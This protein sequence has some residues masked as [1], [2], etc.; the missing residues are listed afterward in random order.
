MKQ[1]FVVGIGPGGGSS[2]T[3]AAARALSAADEIIGY[4]KY[5]ELVAEFTKGKGCFANGMTG[6]RERCARALE[7][8]SRGKTVCLVCSG[9]AGVYGMASLV[10]ELA[11]GF[12]P[13][14]VEIVPGVTAALAG[15]ALLG[16]PLSCDFCVVSLSDLLT[17]REKIAQRL[18]AAGEGDF[19]LALY[20]PRS[21]GR[22]GSLRDACDILLAVR[23]PET[24][25]GW[26][27]NAGRAGES[28]GI[29]QLRDLRDAELDMFCTAFVGN[30]GT[31]VVRRAGREWLLTPRGYT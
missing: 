28:H 8:A 15:A 25:C 1:I 4:E 16:S 20:N 18:R 17:P 2:M 3:L 6:E 9:D 29:C 13:V 5:V 7:R 23:P 30:S 10:I 24:P 31:R 21:R 12:P 26:V 22:P 14:D 11:D 19:A 27:R